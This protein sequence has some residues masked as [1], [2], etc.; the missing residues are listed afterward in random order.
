MKHIAEPDV[1]SNRMKKGVRRRNVRKKN[2][3]CRGLINRTVP[4]INA[5]MS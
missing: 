5:K 3:T 2:E 4:L 1:N